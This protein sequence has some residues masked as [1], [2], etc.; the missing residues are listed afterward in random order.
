MVHLIINP[1][2]DASDRRNAEM[3]A[4]L[5]RNRN[6]RAI[7]MVHEIT[8]PPRPTLRQ[9]FTISKSLI[10]WND[11]VII[12][13]SD[14]YFDETA[15]LL[16]HVGYGE[17]F[18]LSRYE[19]EQSEEFCA[20]VEGSQDAWVFRGPPPDVAAD[21]PL[22][23]PGCD[24]RLAKLLQENGYT[25]YNPSISIKSHHLHEGVKVRSRDD[26]NILGEKL[27][28]WPCTIENIRRES[29]EE[30]FKRGK[31][32]IV[33]LGRLGDIVNCL[34]I[35]F[36][37][38]RQGNLIFW[39]VCREFAPLLTGVS[40][41][42]PV[43]WDGAVKEP[44]AAIEDAKRRGF[45]RVLALQVDGNP[46]PPP[47]KTDSF[48]TESWARA[49]YLSK[50]HILPLVFDQAFE[51]SESIVPAGST[52]PIMAYCLEGHSSPYWEGVRQKMAAWI[53]QTFSQ[54]F[55]LLHL[56]KRYDR[57]DA[58]ISIL[59][60][61]DILISVDTFPLHLAYASGTPT[62]AITEAAW[63][64]SEPRRHWIEQIGYAESAT[65]QG[66]AKIVSAVIALFSG[67]IGPGRLIRNPS[68]EP[69][70][71][72]THGRKLSILVATVAE[73]GNVLKNLLD[74][75]VWQVRENPLAEVVVESDHG[76][77]TLD[78]KRNKLLGM[79]TGEYCFFVEDDDVV[80]KEFVATLL[81]LLQQ[82][83]DGIELGGEGLNHHSPMRTSIARKIG[84]RTV[85]GG[86]EADFEKRLR[87]SGLLQSV[88]SAQ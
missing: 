14:I 38:H 56:E 86:S 78:Q 69:A 23:T 42:T 60:Q 31:I 57:P 16:N 81:G 1:Y 43:I 74:Q 7:S 41:V 51:T 32:A 80:S 19:G 17:C 28:V 66:Q 49:H 70:P 54:D 50:Y 72:F 55:D 83:P 61:V 68:R 8:D 73:R 65:P 64:G 46:Q 67:S 76:E 59:A 36:D 47:Q 45:D 21:F 71:V 79:A 4:A 48:A 18:V 62:I 82:N 27:F 85:E 30:F 63:R 22:G 58:L 37:L 34:P 44:A 5:D 25:V 3:A 84:F 2:R 10:G 39:Y 88:C 52:K 20:N 26:G 33:Q 35:A 9:L 29:G 6:C 13:N 77:T 53:R 11:V 15:E 24:N 40:Y 75:L 87:E 12:A